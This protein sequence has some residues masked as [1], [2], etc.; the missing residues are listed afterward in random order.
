MVLE[1]EDLR[2]L[3]TST[4]IAVKRAHQMVEFMRLV[5]MNEALS[6]SVEN[7]DLRIDSQGRS[8]PQS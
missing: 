3:H 2:N 1:E 5:C 8:R 7:T 4:E 6:L